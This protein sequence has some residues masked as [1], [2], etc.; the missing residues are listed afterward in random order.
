M[1]SRALALQDGKRDLRA[2]QVTL[3]PSSRGKSGLCQPTLLT[4]VEGVSITLPLEPSLHVVQ[5][6]LSMS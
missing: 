6:G 4:S 2:S 3:Q 1:A 5:A